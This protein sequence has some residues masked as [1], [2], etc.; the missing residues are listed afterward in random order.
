MVDVKFT[1]QT[2]HLLNEFQ[3]M[4]TLDHPNILKVVNLKQNIPIKGISDPTSNIKRD[5]LIM[6]F[7]NEGSLLSVIK[8]GL[9]SDLK[10]SILIK[11]V[12]GFVYLH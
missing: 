3:L 10:K 7:A 12:D 4:S 11:L 8:S 5:V 6:E 2:K 9:E 1:K